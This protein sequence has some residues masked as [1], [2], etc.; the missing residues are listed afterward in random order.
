MHYSN[1]DQYLLKLLLKKKNT[2]S[3]NKSTL[4]CSPRSNRAHIYTGCF[5]SRDQ[6]LGD[7]SSFVFIYFI[8]FFV[9]IYFFYFTCIF[10]YHGLFLS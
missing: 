3:I 2:F 6:S 1:S 4:S 10:F 8:N 9:F 5:K 7:R